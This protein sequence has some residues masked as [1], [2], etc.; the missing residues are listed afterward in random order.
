MLVHSVALL[1]TACWDPGQGSLRRLSDHQL[2]K[3]DKWPETAVSHLSSPRPLLRG[4]GT[5]VN[6]SAESSGE[7]PVPDPPPRAGSQGLISG[8]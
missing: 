2:S 1:L 6:V 8:W 5:L 3:G 7:V 4:S